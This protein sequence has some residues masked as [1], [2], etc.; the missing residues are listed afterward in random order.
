MSKYRIKS[1]S[2]KNLEAN[3]LWKNSPLF[4][5]KP[6]HLTSVNRIGISIPSFE[7]AGAKLQS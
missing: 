7:K 2:T 3:S 1:K 6:T 4:F 5:A